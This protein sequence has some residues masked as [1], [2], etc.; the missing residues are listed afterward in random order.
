T[1]VYHRIPRAASMTNQASRELATLRRFS[2]GVRWVWERRPAAPGGRIARCRELVTAMYA[3]A[4]DRLGRDEP[5]AHYYYEHSLPI[6]WR[7]LHGEISATAARAALARAVA[8]RPPPAGDT[9][10]SR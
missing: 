10:G 1:V 9:D 2:E 8:G 6:L 4:E 3:A 5:L 7:A